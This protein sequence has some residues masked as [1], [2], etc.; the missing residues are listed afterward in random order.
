MHIPIQQKK[1]NSNIN[2]RNNENF[3]LKLNDLEE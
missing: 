1:V 2:P 3:K